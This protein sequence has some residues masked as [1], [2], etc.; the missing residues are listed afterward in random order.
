MKT[1]IKKRT[2]ITITISTD[3]LEQIDNEYSKKGF[4]NRSTFIERQIQKQM[5]SPG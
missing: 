3:L 2:R 4:R 5:G 1:K